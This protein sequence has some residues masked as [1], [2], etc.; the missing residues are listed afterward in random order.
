MPKLWGARFTKE[1]DSDA[2]KLSY[3]LKFDSKLVLYD[4]KTNL[5]QAKA[6]NRVSIIGD[7]ELLLIQKTI[8]DLEQEFQ[9]EDHKLFAQQ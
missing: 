3:S 7:K 8:A 5:A 4:L 1:L 6:L 9:Q 2:K